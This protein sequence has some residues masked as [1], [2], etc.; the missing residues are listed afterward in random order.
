MKFRTRK[1]IENYLRCEKVDI[2]GK[3][4][5]FSQPISRCTHYFESATVQNRAICMYNNLVISLFPLRP[6][7][8]SLM[9]YIL[10]LCL[11]LINVRTTNGDLWQRAWAC[12]L[13]PLTSEWNLL[14]FRINSDIM[15]IVVLD[16]C[17][18]VS[19][20]SCQNQMVNVCAP[21]SSVFQTNFTV[22]SKLKN[23]PMVFGTIWFITVFRTGRHGTLFWTKSI[24]ISLF[25]LRLC[26]TTEFLPL[27]SQTQIARTLM[28]GIKFWSS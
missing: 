24:L 3:E 9:T 27:F 13:T 22:I 11:S 8:S 1:I 20:N 21:T 18:D 23:Y 2:F 26:F 14:W 25:Q 4:I 28:N 15:A 6:I 10:L 7:T 12:P 17:K 16:I 5:T 19:L